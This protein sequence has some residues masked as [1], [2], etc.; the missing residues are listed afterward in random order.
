MKTTGG[1]RFD[2]DEYKKFIQNQKQ[3]E[4]V[5]W[6]EFRISE[7]FEVVNSKAYHKT[8]L[9]KGF[10]PYIARTSFNNGLEAYVKSDNLQLNP[11]NTI[12]LGA[13]NAD[14]F[15]QEL[16][17]VTG[18]KMYYLKNK[19]IN[20]YIGLFLV[21][22]LQSSI[23]NCGFGYGKGL[24]GTRLKNRTLFLPIIDSKGNP[25]WQFM[26]GYIKHIEYK[27]I[28]DIVAYYQRKS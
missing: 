14:F 17:Y 16:E 28:K 2:L 4:N 7:V 25:N 10:T 1:G 20:R 13:E 18:N 6:R 5:E 9:Q 26:E 22:V 19:N 21:R 12:S 27:K 8:S 23:K 3:L 24:T 15:Y 11:K